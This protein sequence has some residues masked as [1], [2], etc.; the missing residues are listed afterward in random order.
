MYELTVISLLTISAGVVGFLICSFHRH[1]LHRKFREEKYIRLKGLRLNKMLEYLGVDQ[2]EY[3]RK[4][5][6]QVIERQMY[7]CLQ[8]PNIDECDDCLRDR[9][10]QF[11]MHFCPNYSSLLAQSHFFTE[12][13]NILD[14]L[15]YPG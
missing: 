12:T 10:C 1:Y 4:V 8:C 2:R 9:H 14:K 7:H 3:V 5:P 6:G 15:L 11:D 13:T